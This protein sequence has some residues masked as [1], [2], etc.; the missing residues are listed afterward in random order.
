[1]VVEIEKQELDRYRADIRQRAEENQ[2]Q[3]ERIRRQ[4]E[5]I[6]EQ[7]KPIQEQ[8]ERIR[9][10]EEEIE[11]LK[12]LVEGKADAKTAKKPKFTE[13]Y[14]L[15]RNK[16]NKQKKGRKKSTGR[17]PQEAKRDLAT[18]KVDIYAAGVA[19]EECIRHRSDR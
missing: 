7:A 11:R 6:Q 9:Q 1:M 16:R 17:K 19:R 10:L 14:S 8:A 18:L 15:D 13:N 4:A 12:K 3:A 2:R 5:Q